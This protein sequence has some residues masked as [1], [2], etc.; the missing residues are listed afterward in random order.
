MVLNPEKSIVAPGTV[1]PASIFPTS[2]LVPFIFF[3]IAEAIIRPIA[4]HHFS[5][6]VLLLYFNTKIP[7]H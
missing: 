4:G 3:S 5:F 2:L 6:I 7:Q 1:M